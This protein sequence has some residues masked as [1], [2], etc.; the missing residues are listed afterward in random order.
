MKTCRN[1]ER[2]HFG[3]T[4]APLLCRS[5]RAAPLVLGIVAA[6]PVVSGSDAVVPGSFG[7]SA[8]AS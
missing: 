8:E 3:A 6:Y 4:P 5:Y 7:K 1:G 2:A